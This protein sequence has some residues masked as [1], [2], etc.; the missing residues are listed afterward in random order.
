MFSEDD[1]SVIRHKSRAGCFE[2]S[3]RSYFLLNN[4]IIIAHNSNSFCKHWSHIYGVIQKNTAEESVMFL[5]V[6][7]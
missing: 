4:N 6:Y 3:T 2:Q 1:V 5:N 7:L